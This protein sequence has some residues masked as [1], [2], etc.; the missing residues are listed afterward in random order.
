MTGPTQNPAHSQRFTNNRFGYKLKNAA[1][2]GVRNAAL[3]Y[4][5]ITGTATNNGDA[6]VA[7][8]SPHWKASNTVAIT[9]STQPPSLDT[10]SRGRLNTTNNPI[11]S[12]MNL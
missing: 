11:A 4:T 9:T 2:S 6:R 1:S 12:V 3:T 5:S 8:D 10:K 7:A